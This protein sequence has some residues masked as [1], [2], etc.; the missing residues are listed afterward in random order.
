MVP[1]SHKRPRTHVA[2][3]S[4]AL[5]PDHRLQNG[6]A[7]AVVALWG[8]FPSL[9]ITVFQKN[10][11]FKKC[12]LLKREKFLVAFL[13]FYIVFKVINRHIPLLAFYIPTAQV[14]S[15]IFQ[16]SKHLTHEK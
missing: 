16:I 3:S 10:R 12:Y 14:D 9:Y 5:A 8:V 11:F 1:T 7:L 13:I 15:K 4:D 2:D 6:P